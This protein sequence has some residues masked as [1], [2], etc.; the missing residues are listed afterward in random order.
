M[1]KKQQTLKQNISFNGKGLHTGLQVEMTV[2]PAEE[3]H[4][5]KFQRVD[6][7]NQPII[8]ANADNVTATSRGTTLEQN[9]VKVTTIEHIMAALWGM[10]I[11]NALIKVNAPEAPILD[12]SAG[13]YVEAIKKAGI[14]E[15]NAE[16]WY[17]E[18]KEKMVFK[19]D[20]GKEIILL[21][22]DCFS[23]DLTIDFN[24]QVLHNQSARLATLDDFAEQIAPCRTFVFFHELE[25]LYKNNLIKGGDFENAIV[26]VE[27]PVPQEELDHIAKLLNK[28]SVERIPEGYL[29][30]LELRFPNEPAR[31]KLLDI[32]GDL[33][34]LGYR[35]K[36]KVLAFKPGHQLNTTTAKAMRKIAKKE[37]QKPIAP[38]YNPNI[39]PLYDI[40][41]IKRL[42]PHRPPFLLVDKILSSTEDCVIGVKNVS[43][44]EP[45]FVG[46]FPDEPVMPGVLIV[47][48][49]AQVGGILVL[50]TVDNPENYSTYF[51]KIDKVK[52]RKK[53]VP[54]DTLIFK[55]TLAEPIRRGIVVMNGQAFVGDTLV[56][57][58]ELTAQVIKNR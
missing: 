58:G 39:E 32:I 8:D 53:V 2:C 45:F 6:V 24:S 4:G 47:E 38:V 14:V 36:G 35:I 16:R 5:I 12:G 17:F 46:H 40:N 50:G 26:I 15:Q 27:K 43:M 33:A 51:L 44:N 19:G 20:N 13:E 28:P 23:V 21:P 3:N 48:A 41:H 55:L 25:A 18:V 42:L 10:G 31:H 22:D 37:S 54:G 34:L 1:Q 49:M 56:T 7:E 11:D 29:N 30:N 52:Y 9:G 57:E